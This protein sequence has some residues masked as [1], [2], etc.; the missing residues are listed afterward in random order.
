MEN[1]E[2]LLVKVLWVCDAISIR[3]SDLNKTDF[4]TTIYATSI[5]K[6]YFFVVHNQKPKM[7][8]QG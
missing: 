6:C 1:K 7:E 4:D 8:N 2:N 5:V 3:V